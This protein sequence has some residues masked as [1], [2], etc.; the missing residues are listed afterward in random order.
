MNK[1]QTLEEKWEN[2][3]LEN[4]FIFYHVFHNNP[5]LCKILLEILLKIEIDHIEMHNEETII[6]DYEAKGV[7]LD[8]YAKNETQA[9]NLEMQVA[10]TKDLTK[11]IRYY[12]ALIDVDCLKS[13]ELY[14]NLK[15]SYVIFICMKDIFGMGLPVYRFENLCSENIN[16]SLNDKTYKYFFIAP[17][18][19]K[20]TDKKQFAFF[21]FLTYKKQEDPFTEKLAQ[22]TQNAK[23]NLQVR[24][25]Y[26][27]YERLKAYARLDGLAEGRAEG[28]EEGRAEGLKEGRAKGL[29]EGRAEGR[30]VGLKEGR[31][32]GL[33]EGRTEGLKEGRAEGLEEGRAEGLKEGRTEGLKEG[34]L[35]AALKTAIIAVQEF[36]LDPETVAEKFGV[37]FIT[38][39]KALETKD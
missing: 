20:L 3:G 38:L 37:D 24:N 16:L 33:E 18:C 36:N 5:D 7:R 9:F 25:K 22:L 39:K 11:R 13:G 4:N 32:E 8:V 35:E 34:K 23:I 29:E 17:N 28:L 26:M 30:A 15:D 19:D 6:V 14:N 10:D 1:E 31:A 12:Q 2:A 21:N 27:E